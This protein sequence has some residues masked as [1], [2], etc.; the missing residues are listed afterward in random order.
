MLLRFEFRRLSPDI[1]RAFDDHHNFAVQVLSVSL[2]A[3]GFIY[4]TLIA[5]MEYNLP[6]LLEYQDFV[7]SSHL[8][9][10]F[11]LTLVA[12]FLKKNCLKLIDL[13]L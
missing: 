2:I 3:F 1:Q 8:F 12:I 10:L 11:Y 4:H 9:G 6:S 5:Q 7:A 13:K